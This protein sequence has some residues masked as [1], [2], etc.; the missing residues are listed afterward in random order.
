MVKERSLQN[1][2]ENFEDNLNGQADDKLLKNTLRPRT[3][4]LHSGSVDKR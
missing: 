3:A 4:A 2:R 1:F